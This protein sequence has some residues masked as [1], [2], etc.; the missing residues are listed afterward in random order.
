MITILPN[1]SKTANQEKYLHNESPRKSSVGKVNNKT[2]RSK[3][4][5]FKSEIVSCK[6]K[7]NK[8]FSTFRLKLITIRNIYSKIIDIINRNSMKNER[9]FHSNSARFCENQNKYFLKK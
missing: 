9:G 7:I 2:R 8:I 6:R 5:F 3:Y 4:R 1:A